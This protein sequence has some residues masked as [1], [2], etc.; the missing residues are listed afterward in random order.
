MLSPSGL[1]RA[2]EYGRIGKIITDFL[3]QIQPLRRTLAGSCDDW[4]STFDRLQPV[5]DAPT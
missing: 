2:A 3:L 5:P 1:E 4:F